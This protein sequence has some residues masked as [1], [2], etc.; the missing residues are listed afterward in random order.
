MIEKCKDCGKC[1]LDTEMSISMKDIDEI[2]KN[3]PKKLNRNDF[4]MDI[5][6]NHFQLKNVD[7][8]CFFFNVK[9]KLCKIYEYRPQGCRFYPIIFDNDI[10]NCI[11]D[12]FCPRTTLFFL[13]KKKFS[14]KCNQ[15]K[16]FLLEQLKII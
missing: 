8:H 6:K 10:K 7:G 13:D 3:Y 11:Y 2:L 15:I 5:S 1:C 4:A 14:K 16:N 9:N 12:N